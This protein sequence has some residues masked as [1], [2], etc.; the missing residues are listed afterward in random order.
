MLL[1]ARGMHVSCR[2]FEPVALSCKAHTLRQTRHAT[3]SHRYAPGAITS[4]MAV[5]V[6]GSQ[7]N[8]LAMAHPGTKHVAPA[9]AECTS[10]RAEYADFCCS[11]D[12]SSTAVSTE[13]SAA[14]STRMSDHEVSEVRCVHVTCT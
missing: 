5:A 10:V 6:V 2:D 7:S 8:K 1:A 3:I 11:G 12:A 9:A 14:G 13:A 4:C